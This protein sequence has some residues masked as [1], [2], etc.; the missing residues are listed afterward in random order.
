MKSGRRSLRGRRE[1]QTLSF[2]VW[3]HSALLAVDLRSLGFQ[4]DAHAARRKYKKEI[5]KL[6]PDLEAYNRQKEIAMGL[7]PGTLSQNGSSSSFSLTSFDPTEASSSQVRHFITWLFSLDSESGLC[8]WFRLLTSNRWRQKVST[9][10]RTACYT[11]TTSPLMRRLTVLSARLTRSTLD[12]ID[13]FALSLIDYFTSIDKRRKFSRK[14]PNED[15]GDIT[16]INEKNRIFNKK[17]GISFRLHCCWSSLISAPRLHV[18]STNI[19]QRYVPASSV[20]PHY[21]AQVHLVL[22]D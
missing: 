7:A 14:R 3:L 19:P 16:Y 20:G 9:A 10:T 11:P 1:E 4:D 13:F 2:T 21:K 15:T 22:L 8:R 5:D 18:T 6:K 17:V 12:R